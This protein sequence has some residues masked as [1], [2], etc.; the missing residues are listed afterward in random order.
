M[1]Q[2]S[3][4]VTTNLAAQVGRLPSYGS[5]TSNSLYL[6][7][8]ALCIILVKDTVAVPTSHSGVIA[9]IN[10][11]LNASNYHG[12]AAGNDQNC[13]AIISGVK[14]CSYAS[15]NCIAFDGAVSF[16]PKNTGTVGGAIFTYLA[17]S[18]PQS[19]P[20]LN[21]PL[22]QATTQSNADF[23]VGNSEGSIYNYLF[24]TDLI[25][26]TSKS[27]VILDTTNLVTGV[28]SVLYGA[29]LKFSNLE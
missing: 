7:N 17:K 15:P 19:D 26:T 13:L 14:S 18:N 2:L 22:S 3:S 20:A 12:G 6:I 10:S 4:Q 11:A 27:N 1:L 29:S 23:Y 9:Y 16:A 8:W 28:D 21:Y 24:I 25:G 5:N